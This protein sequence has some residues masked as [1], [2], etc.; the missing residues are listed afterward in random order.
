MPAFV[1][2]ADIDPLL[3]HFCCSIFDMLI[4]LTGAHATTFLRRTRWAALA[5]C[6]PRLT[7][8]SHRQE[9]SSPNKQ[10]GWRA[11]RTTGEELMLRLRYLVLS[12]LLAIVGTVPAKAADV[13]LGDGTMLS[14]KPFYIV[15]YVEVDPNDT[16][17]AKKLIAKHSKASKK[18]AGNLRYEALERI[19]RKNH[20]LILEAWTD[21][22]A[23]SRYS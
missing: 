17:Q 11:I 5:I 20:F 23:A 19:G 4:V 18:D 1:S 2:K 16:A 21:Q 7:S 8:R 12:L 22:D 10:N 3:T 9:A 13:K 15:T 6:I 14:A